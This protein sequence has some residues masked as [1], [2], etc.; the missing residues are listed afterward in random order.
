[1]GIKRIETQFLALNIGI[2][3]LITALLTTL[4]NFVQISALKRLS[5]VTVFFAYAI[6]AWAINA[7]HIFDLR[8]V[9]TPLAQRVGLVLVLAA[10]IAAAIWALD[11]S[12]PHPLALVLV[13]AGFCSLAFWLDRQSRDWLDL[14]GTRQ[15][16]ASR[17]AFIDVALTQRDP[18]ELTAAFD[19]LLRAQCQTKY[20]ALLVDHGDIQS[21][22]SLQFQ[23]TRPGYSAL[24][25]IGWATPESLERRRSDPALAD[26]NRYLAQHALGAIVISPRGSRQPSLLVALGTKD[27][28]W[29]FTYP[30][31]Q[32]LQNIAELMDN[33]LTRSRL[34]AQAAAQARIEHLAMMSRGLAHDLRNLI[35][36]IS[37][38]LVHTEGRFTAGGTEA[39]VHAAAQHSVTAMGDYVREALFFSERLSPNFTTVDLGKLF[40]VART[41]A[42][43]HAAR[44]QVTIAIAADSAG[45]LCADFVLLQRM[46]ANLVNNALDASA[47]GQ[48]ITL[49]AARTLR[50]R[51][52]LQVS[53]NGCGVPPENLAKIFDPYFTTKEF[54]RDVRGFGL[55]LTICQKIAHLHHGSISVQSQPGRGATFT[56]DLPAAPPV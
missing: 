3:A 43:D 16:A 47:S 34:A 9:F 36:P 14:D 6:S 2:A 51:V 56:I 11:I 18:D 46:L 44:R 15:L 32:R 33:V 1:M 5:I 53:D 20:A 31:I 49:S 10:G 13:I 54:G 19:A 7:H 29:P 12:M 48:T 40:A 28:A 45:P 38:F 37:S 24:C 55:G 30:E 25:D 41:T 4:G 42:A 50:D 39:E 27:H 8:Q 23:K 35:T 21:S 52:R 17:R 22:A 26:L